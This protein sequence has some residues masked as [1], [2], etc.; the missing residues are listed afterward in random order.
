M[1]IP[2]RRFQ[3]RSYIINMETLAKE[4]STCSS[5]DVHTEEEKACVLGEQMSYRRPKEGAQTCKLHSSDEGHTH[6][7]FKFEQVEK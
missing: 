3:I 1:Q 2:I 4:V 7:S 6:V 5:D